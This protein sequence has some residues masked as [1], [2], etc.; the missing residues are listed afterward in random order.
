MSL[1][2]PLLIIGGSGLLGEALTTEL[3]TAGQRFLAPARG[4]L[5]LA[6]EGEL[7]RY[8]DDQRPSALINA[9]AFTDVARAELPESLPEVSLLNLLAP[10]RMA[11]ACARLHIPFV[12][13]STDYVFD[14]AKSSPYREDD[15]VSPLQVYGR[16]KLD[17][18]NAVRETCPAAVVVRTSTLF[19][20]GRRARPHYIDAVLRKA[21]CGGQLD[22]V[23][24]P[25]SSPTYAP[26]LAL[27]ILRLLDAGAKGTVHVSNAGSC[28]RMELAVEAIRLAGPAFRVNV[29]ERAESAEGPARP[30]Y[31]VL[32][33]SRYIKLTG[34][35][36]RSWSEALAAYID[37]HS[38]SI[39]P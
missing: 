35:S 1:A 22:L 25:I 20:P 11:Q 16:S 5:D 18:E 3:S 26:D 27:A 38:A 39:L 14:G 23:R 15:A 8:I 33:G 37:N 13:I 19:G 29:G 36:M 10:R 28:S 9:A 7:E 12:H 34:R 30:S 32:D 4:Q 2:G 17:G 6:R 21:S 31:S 24:L